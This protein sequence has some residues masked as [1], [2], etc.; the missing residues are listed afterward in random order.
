MDLFSGVNVN[1]DRF[2]TSSANKFLNV[3]SE[4]GSWIDYL[5]DNECLYLYDLKSKVYRLHEVKTIYPSAY[6][7]YKIFRELSPNDIRVVILGQD[8]YHDGNATGIAFACQNKVSPSL[9]QIIQAIKNSTDE[10]YFDNPNAS[11][12][13]LVKQGVFL[14]NTCLTVEKGKPN[15]HKDLGY[16]LFISRVLQ[17]ISRTQSNIVWL[18]WGSE[19]KKYKTLIDLNK[20]LVLEYEHPA[21]ASYDN[22]QWNC[23]HFNLTNEYLIK[24]N[25][26]KIKWI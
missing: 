5:T 2:S 21:A 20:H 6:D 19:A 10:R 4:I 15:S 24:H 8:P 17:I 3:G 25:K 12:D 9:K 1:Q 26:E 13:F 18:L 11:L 7:T 23:N 14:L 16:N 22:R